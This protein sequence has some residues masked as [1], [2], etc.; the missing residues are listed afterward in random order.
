[1]VADTHRD[2]GP[3]GRLDVN[4]VGLWTLYV[5]EVRRFLKVLPQT[6]LAPVISALLFAV[7]F[8]VA[9]SGGRA[10]ESAVSYDMFLAPGLIMMQILQNAFM[11]TSS[12]LLT[13]K[14]QGNIVDILMPPLSPTEVMMAYVAGG[15]TRGMLVG[16][17]SAAALFAYAPSMFMISH[18]WAILFYGFTASLLL[19]AMGVIA[20]V[21]AEKFDHMAVVTTF[22]IMP[23]TFL[24]GTFYAVDRLSGVWA[25]VTHWN[26]FYFLIDGFRYGFIG[27]EHSRLGLGMVVLIGL[28]VASLIVCQ[29]IFASG[30]RLKS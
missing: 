12:S 15:V 5:K 17:A 2:E 22:V 26:P 13:S 8:R 25:F 23:L 3:F 1:M 28:S 16:V 11:N 30:Y 24:S 29:R 4:W 21:W 20:G 27:V 19:S 14:M 18:I 9:L 7:I 6:V 10:P